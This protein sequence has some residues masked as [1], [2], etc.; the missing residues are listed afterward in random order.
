M[1][2]IYKLNEV[3]ITHDITP[4]TRTHMQ[5]HAHAGTHVNVCIN[6]YVC[7]AHILHAF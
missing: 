7:V 1:R 5:V 3:F 6:M 2:N 4:A